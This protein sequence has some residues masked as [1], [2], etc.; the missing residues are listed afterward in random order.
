MD[1]Q[2]TD[3]LGRAHDI[4]GI[5]CLVGGD[6]DKT[7]ALEFDGAFCDVFRAEYVYANRLIREVLQYGDVFI[8]GGVEDDLGTVLVK[9][10]GDG[11]FL[12]DVCE[13]ME[14]G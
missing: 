4:G 8:G 7:F 1:E 12:G 11:V 9:D 3:A 6:E 5:D 14:D 10:T 13:G 2:F